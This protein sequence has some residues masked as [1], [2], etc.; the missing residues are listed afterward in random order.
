MDAIWHPVLGDRMQE[1]VIIGIKMDQES[2]QAELDDCLVETPNYHPFPNDWK[3]LE[4]PFPI[5]Q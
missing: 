1:I 5:W 3:T 4:D 2:I